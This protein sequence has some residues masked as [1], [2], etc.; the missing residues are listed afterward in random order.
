MKTL[1]VVPAYNESQNIEKVVEDLKV[2]APHVDYVV[3]N[4]CSGDNTREILSKNKFNF[5]DLPIN[6]G[7]GGC[8][9]TG[10]RYAYENAYDIAVQLDGDGQHDASYIEALIRPIEEGQANVVVGSRFLDYEGF[11]SSTARRFGIRTISNLIHILS[12]VKVNDVTSGMRAY[13]RQMIEYLAKNYEDDYPE[14]DA[15]LAAALMKMK[16]IEIPVQMRERMGGKSSIN[17]KRSVYYMIK[18]CS[19][20]VLMK[21]MST[22]K[23]AAK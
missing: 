21:L 10:F 19:S 13:D 2:K 7:I 14:P 20:L 18:V 6:L 23:G 9:Q 3:V 1:V 17:I 4:D 22:W 11:Q 8:V 15:L 5:I 12:G 16:I